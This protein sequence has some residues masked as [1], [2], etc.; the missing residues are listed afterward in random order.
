[1]RNPLKTKRK[2][3]ELW[4]N[5]LNV[6]TLQFAYKSKTTLLEHMTRV[7]VITNLWRKQGLK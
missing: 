2:Q 3:L 1:M 7:T 5:P 6:Y 4:E